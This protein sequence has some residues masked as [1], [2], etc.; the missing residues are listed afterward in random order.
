MIHA[1]GMDDQA[2]HQRLDQSRDHF[3][4]GDPRDINGRK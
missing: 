4:H 1:I 3:F 2:R